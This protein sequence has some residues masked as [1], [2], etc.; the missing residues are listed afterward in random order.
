[1]TYKQ[2]L[3]LFG[4]EVSI[5]FCALCPHFFKA[6]SFK[7]KNWFQVST[8]FRALRLHFVKKF[9][10][11]SFRVLFC[12]EKEDD[13]GFLI[14]QIGSLILLKIWTLVFH[15]KETCPYFLFCDVT[16]LCGKKSYLKFEVC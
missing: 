1:M 7:K 16:S 15:N 10:G 3:M 11:Q 4:F 12:H 2:F 13:E 14:H 6:P 8:W 9:L 5:R